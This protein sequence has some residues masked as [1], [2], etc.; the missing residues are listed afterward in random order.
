M[1]FD[2]FGQGTTRRSKLNP[3]ERYFGTFGEA[4]TEAQRRANRDGIRWKVFFIEG[5]FDQ[6]YSLESEHETSHGWMQPKYVA[7]PLT[8]DTDFIP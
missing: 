8:L 6:F 2:I 7:K 4:K 1:F 3:D 5:T